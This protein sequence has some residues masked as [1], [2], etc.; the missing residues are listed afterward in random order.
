MTPADFRSLIAAI[1][2]SNREAASA[3]VIDE[4]LVRRLKSG[5]EEATPTIEARAVAVAADAL[6]AQMIR[7]LGLAAGGTVEFARLRVSAKAVHVESEL[8]AP[9][10]R[11]VREA[12][13]ERLAR[14][15]LKIE[16]EP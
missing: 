9:V 4:R 8:S 5:D 11:A 6:A 3:F 10:A 13:L 7:S 12:I 15:G 2:L 1:G 14:T 16:K